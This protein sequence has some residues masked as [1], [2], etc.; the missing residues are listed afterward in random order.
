MTKQFEVVTAREGVAYVVTHPE[1]D[2]YVTVVKG[3]E[4]EAFVYS[5]K[6]RD[7][8]SVFGWCSAEDFD[9]YA[10]QYFKDNPPKGGRQYEAKEGEAWC[11]TLER[12]SLV[13]VWNVLVDDSD[14]FYFWDK[15]KGSL[16]FE[17]IFSPRITD[18]VRLTGE[19]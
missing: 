18:A 4:L 7:V 5:F 6:T 3:E 1:R 19:E 16:Q 17:S 14:F 15:E 2:D 9:D 12:G 11:I 8:D 13:E 10:E